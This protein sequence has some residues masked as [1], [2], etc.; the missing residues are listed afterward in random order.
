MLRLPSSCLRKSA[1]ACIAGVQGRRLVLHRAGLPQSQWQSAPRLEQHRNLHSIDE[2]TRPTEPPAVEPPAAEPQVDAAPEPVPDPK[3][4]TFRE[5]Y[6]LPPATPSAQY[7]F[8]KDVVIHGFLGKRRDKGFSLSFCDVQTPSHTI[9]IVSTW[10]EEGSP[11]QIAHESLK[12]VPSYSPV[13]VQGTLEKN[14]RSVSELAHPAASS[15]SL[16]LRLK[17]IR[18]LNQFPKDIIVSKDAVWPLKQRHLQLRF[19]P[20]LR[21]RLRVRNRIMGAMRHLLQGWKFQ[22]VETPLLFKSTP[23]GAR[24]FLVPTRRRG[25]AYALPQ[26][27]QQYKQILMA[28]GLPN[29]FQFAKCF[30]D[31]DHRA[32]RQPEFTQLDLEISF[33]TGAVVREF[34]QRLMGKVFNVLRAEFAPVEINGI[35]H[36]AFKRRE[37]SQLQESNSEALE[38]ESI[39]EEPR[40]QTS[41]PSYPQVPSVYPEFSY[42]TAMTAFGTDKPDLRITSRNASN[43]TRIDPFLPRSF[44]EMITDLEDPI[45]EAVKFR[46]GKGT[47]PG[48]SARFIREFMDALPNTPLKLTSGST[49][50]VFV[51][52]PSKPVQGLSALGHEAAG[53]LAEMSTQYW[54]QCAKGDIIIIHARKNEPF[55]GGSTDLGRLRTAIHANA[56]EKG[57]I[58]KWHVFKPVWIRDFPLFTPE[59]NNDNNDGKGNS[60]EGQGQGGAAGFS[61]TH[62]P[63]TA[64]L[65]PEDL[66]LLRTDPLRAKADHYDLVINGVEV[67][68]GSRRIH[69]AEVQEYVLRDVLR[70][71]DAG[72]AQFA[73]LLEALR[74]GCPPHAGFAFGFDRLL[75]VLCD[76]PSVKDV[77][78]FPKNNKGEDPL[79]GSPNKTTPE[80]Q[81]TYHLFRTEKE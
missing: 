54:E 60:G 43:I 2:S 51:I 63:F 12:A 4:E 10:Q 22:E 55:R 42:D 69:V 28:G 74:A 5:A 38:G 40:S 6:H 49:P 44:I 30:R 36:P 72:V 9:Q 7:E 1:Q 52:D 18:C 20:I 77:I 70:M 21:Q 27:P 37:V 23:E 32:D 71:S 26:S 68:G 53:R 57:L 46:L 58:P 15:K 31:E 61:S 75:T 59:D 11:E 3:W 76:V 50:G 25:F 67:G 41:P 33:A 34:V 62:H 65:G 48:H 47:S 73:H 24:E 13:W 17:S 64:P 56:V 19:D 39:I 29:Y 66:D 80:Q 14:E 78:A 8:G 81:K 16:D 35:H 79:V 45:V